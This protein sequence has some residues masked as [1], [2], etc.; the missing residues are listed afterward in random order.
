MAHKIE[1][2]STIVLFGLTETLVKGLGNV[3]R[4][5][6]HAVYSLSFLSPSCCLSFIEQ[7]NA[8]LVFCASQPDHYRPLLEAIKLSKPA[9]PLIVVS[10]LPETSEWIETLEAGASDYCAPPFEPTQIQWMLE[11]AMK[12]RPAAA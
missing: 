4:Q 8:Q 7:L 9:L 1:S 5:K 6:G 12:S 11:G 10:G 2:S 3:L